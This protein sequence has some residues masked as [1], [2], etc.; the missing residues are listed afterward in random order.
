MRFGIG[1]HGWHWHA[2]ALLLALV[3]A[4]L[5]LLLMHRPTGGHAYAAE[6]PPAGEPPA[7]TEPPA[8]E[9]AA[10]MEPPAGEPDSG[11]IAEIIDSTYTVGPAEFFALDLPTNLPSAK[12]VHLFG[13]VT[14]RGRGKDIVVRIFRSR[15][16]DQWLKQKGGVKPR[17][18]WTSA[19]SRNLT[20][21]QELPPGEPIVL[22]LDNGYSIRT[23]KQVTCQLQIRYLRHPVDVFD[24]EGG[25]GLAGS[26][27]GSAS[28]A[29]SV[30][31]NLPPPRSNTEEE[32]PPPP[33]PPPEGY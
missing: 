2:R 3:L 6:P 27:G 26:P 1:N 33:P 22:L 7:A 9:P 21:D 10:A 5:A 15:D 31:E 8:G 32:L 12:A 25:S 24:T 29:D 18:L 20:L 19:R 30:Q 14:T 17:A 28:S 23:A 4:L 13:T 11:Y 16:Y